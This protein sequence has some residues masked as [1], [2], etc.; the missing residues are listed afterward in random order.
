MDIELVAGISAVIIIIGLIEVL[1]RVAGLNEKFA[2]VIAII[3][4]LA[5]SFGLSYYGETKVFEAIILGLAVGLSAVGLFSG[6]KNT[7][8][9]IR[10]NKKLL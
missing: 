7:V 4:G 5:A 2:P 10:N 9:G 6:T 1:K 3:L 8:E